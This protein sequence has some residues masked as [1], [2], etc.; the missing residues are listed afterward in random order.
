GA[1]VV[2]GPYALA[3]AGDELGLERHRRVEP[4][5]DV[6]VRRHLPPRDLARAVAVLVDDRDRAERDADLLVADELAHHR[7]EP[8]VRASADLQLLRRPAR[9][10]GEASAPRADEERHLAPPHRVA[11]PLARRESEPPAR[12]PGLV[13]G[14]QAPH[15]LTG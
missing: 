13:A 10:G 15:H 8:R 2:L 9:E 3:D 12:E 6:E 11:E 7:H 14:E 1:L 4:A 5:D